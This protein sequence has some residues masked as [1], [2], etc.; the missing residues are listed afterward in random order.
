LKNERNLSIMAHWWGGL[1]KNDID[2]YDLIKKV[3]KIKQFLWIYGNKFDIIKSHMLNDL[4][5]L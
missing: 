3:K 2:T 1:G 5:A 4:S